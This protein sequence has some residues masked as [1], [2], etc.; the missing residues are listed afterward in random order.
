[1]S[2]FLDYHVMAIQL[3]AKDVSRILLQP[4]HAPVISYEAGQYIEVSHTDGRVSYLSIA[5]APRDDAILEFHL[6]HPAENE[7]AQAL[8]RMARTEKKWQLRGPLGRCTVSQL[9]PD[10]PILFLAQGTGFAPV[11]AVIEALIQAD[12]PLLLHVY[13]FSQ[14]QE[15]FFLTEQISRWKA[16]HPLFIFTPIILPSAFNEDQIES[17]LNQAILATYPDLSAYQVYASGPRSWVYRIFH[18]FQQK[19]L[20]RA[21]FFSDMFE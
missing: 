13:W 14:N 1:M 18:A 19:G 11:K 4:L 20:P 2:Q 21:L 15:D 16:S 8:L 9:H 10:K 6:F 17:V 3:L 7:K 12:F 5:C